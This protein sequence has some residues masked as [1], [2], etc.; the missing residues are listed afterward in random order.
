MIIGISDFYYVFIRISFHAHF[1]NVIVDFN[2]L[3]CVICLIL[4]AEREIKLK[5]GSYWLKSRTGD[6]DLEDAFKTFAKIRRQRLWNLKSSLIKNPLPIQILILR[7]LQT[8]QIAKFII[9]SYSINYQSISANN[10]IEISTFF[11]QKSNPIF[12]FQYP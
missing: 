7:P 4:V 12:P 9:Y 5:L 3:F 10:F 6:W 8:H 11:P 1:P 2:Q